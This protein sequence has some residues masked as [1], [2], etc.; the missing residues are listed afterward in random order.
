MSAQ[1]PT[2]RQRLKHAALAIERHLSDLSLMFDRKLQDIAGVN[3]ENFV[4]IDTIQERVADLQDLNMAQLT[5]AIKYDAK[6]TLELHPERDAVRRKRP[7]KEAESLDRML[8]VDDVDIT[9][10]EEDPT[11]IFE[12][13]FLPYPALAPSALALTPTST[14][15]SSSTSSTSYLSS[16]DRDP[17][18]SPEEREERELIN[19]KTVIRPFGANPTRVFQGFCFVEYPTEKL[20]IEMHSKILARDRSVRVMPM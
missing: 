15:S 7:F 1:K 11:P 4:D 9:G 14:L 19:H 6:D 8:F 18:S 20:A 3:G 13:L 17:P 2:G 12:Q 16:M 10:S 5:R